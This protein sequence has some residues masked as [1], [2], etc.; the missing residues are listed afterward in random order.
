MDKE[1]HCL[2]RSILLSHSLVGWE[3]GEQRKEDMDVQQYLSRM[4]QLSCHLFD[5]GGWKGGSSRPRRRGNF[6]IR[7]LPLRRHRPLVERWKVH[8]EED[9]VEANERREGFTRI[10]IDI[11]TVQAYK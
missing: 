1:Y 9:G 7:L 5:V 4:W 2:S 10:Y 6:H 8:R 11:L 3:E